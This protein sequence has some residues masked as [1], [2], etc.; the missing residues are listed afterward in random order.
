M[1]LYFKSHNS[2]MDFYRIVPVFGLRILVKPLRARP[3]LKHCACCCFETSHTYLGSLYDPVTMSSPLTLE[4]IFYRIV[5]V[6]GLRILVK[7]LHARLFLRHCA[8]C[9]LEISHTYSGSLDDL[10]SKVL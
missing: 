3:F 2:G 10:V 4:W 8:C 6:F 1:T 5:P 7:P 9:C